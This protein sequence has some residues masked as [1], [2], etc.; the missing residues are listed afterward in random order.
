MTS[1]EVAGADLGILGSAS[2]VWI[3]VNCQSDI[4]QVQSYSG[5]I[6]LLDCVQWRSVL[7][8]PLR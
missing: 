5:R 3:E 7:C 8:N 4:S 6:F 2:S 1:Q